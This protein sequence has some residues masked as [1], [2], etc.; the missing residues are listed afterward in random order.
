MLSDAEVALGFRDGSEAGLA[1]AY[2]RWSSL[3]FTFAM[4]SQGNR[5]EAGT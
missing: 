3:V 4:R 2:S 5:E 1:G